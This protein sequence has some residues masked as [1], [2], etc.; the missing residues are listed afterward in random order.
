M[1]CNL[2]AIDGLA[3]AKPGFIDHLIHEEYHARHL[4]LVTFEKSAS[5]IPR[6]MRL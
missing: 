5:H 3:T 1:S 4:D 6:V 2:L